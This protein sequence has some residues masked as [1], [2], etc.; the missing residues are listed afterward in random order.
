MKRNCCVMQ[1]TE[2][3][4]GL[5]YNANIKENVPMKAHHTERVSRGGY[6]V[7]SDM[8]A[9]KWR[10]GGVPLPFPFGMN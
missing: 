7:Q 10:N 8:L 5:M 2:N 6:S 3:A 9:N 1:V 4:A